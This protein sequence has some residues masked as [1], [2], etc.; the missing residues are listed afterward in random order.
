MFSNRYIFIYSTAMVII[1]AALLSSAAMLLQPMQEKNMTIAK[2]Q[3][4]LAAINIKATAGDA[5]AM[6]QQYFTTELAIN[7]AGQIASIYRN[8]KLEEGEVRPFDID[9]KKE[10]YNKKM[11][12]PYIV[13]LFI[14][15]IEGDTLYIVPLR[16]VGLWGPL[17]GNIAFGPD[18]NE[19]VGADFSHDKETPGLGAE[20]SLKAFSD[21]FIGKTMFD[22]AGNFVSIKVVKGGVSTLP[23]AQQNHGVDAISGGTITS[24]GVT[25]ML[26]NCLENYIS[27]IK[28]NIDK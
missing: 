3:G 23:P 25:D 6:Y 27:Y 9:L 7:Q 1:V 2:I 20:I 21:Q 18:F 5:E 15:N 24:N 4:I 14:A 10:L 16:G 8:G 17:Y 13:P 19:I 26:D 28:N 12:Q 22:D 11:G